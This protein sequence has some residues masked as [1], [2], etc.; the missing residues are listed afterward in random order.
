[1]LIAVT[2][3]AALLLADNVR[4]RRGPRQSPEPEQAEPAPRALEAVRD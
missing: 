1:M 4:R 2:P 3:G